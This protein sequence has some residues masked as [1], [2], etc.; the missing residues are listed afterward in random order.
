[1]H[2]LVLRLCWQLYIIRCIGKSQAVDR[3][4]HSYMAHSAL[5][6]WPQ[7]YRK[8]RIEEE[9]N[10]IPWHLSMKIH[11]METLSALL[12]LYEGN[13]LVTEGLPSKEGN[14]LITSRFPSKKASD[15]ELWCYPKQTVGKTV[16][17][18]VIWN[19]ITLMWQHQI[20]NKY[21]GAKCH[22]KM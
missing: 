16:E 2:H 3:V 5:Y 11:E 10:L 9:F 13:P 6:N 18:L 8:T 22:I 7:G 19:A 21:A 14:L 17:L 20:A 15:V 12:A 4:I 1:M